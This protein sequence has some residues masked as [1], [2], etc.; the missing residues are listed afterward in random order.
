[1]LAGVDEKETSVDSARMAGGEDG[2]EEMSD[3]VY[4]LDGR[5]KGPET[6]GVGVE[7]Y[8]AECCAKLFWDCERRSDDEK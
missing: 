8:D 5:L 2:A 4:A 6:C 3:S 7:R 1:L